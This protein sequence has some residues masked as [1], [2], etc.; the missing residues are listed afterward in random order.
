MSMRIPLLAVALVTLAAPAAADCRAEIAAVKQKAGIAQS[1][2]QS[3]EKQQSA[4]SGPSGQPAQQN[5]SAQS[6]KKSPEMGEGAGPPESWFGSSSSKKAAQHKLENAAVMAEHGKEDGC[7]QIV[8]EVRRMMED[9]PKKGTWSP[10]QAAK[11]KPD[12]AKPD[13]A[14]SE[15]GQ[16]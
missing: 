11:A 7:M 3:P 1:K 15:P 13:A 4:R 8:Q 9:N 6:G 10:P 5:Q 14:K 16:Q 2:E 12:A